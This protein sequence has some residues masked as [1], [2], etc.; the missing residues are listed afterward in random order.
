MKIWRFVLS[1]ALSLSLLPSLAQS[2]TQIPKTL[3]WRITGKAGHHISYLYGTMHL[4]D[5][6]VFNLSDS[7]YEAIHRADG[8]AMESD[9]HIRL[10]CVGPWD[11]DPAKLGDSGIPVTIDFETPFDVSQ[12]GQQIDRLLEKV[13]HSPQETD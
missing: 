2:S 12:A 9:G 6:R 4:T 1:L 7:L 11:L 3:L 13:L 10:A 8:F 5:E